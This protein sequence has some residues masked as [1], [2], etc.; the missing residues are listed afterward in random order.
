MPALVVTNLHVVLSRA[1]CSVTCAHCWAA[2][3]QGSRTLCAALRAPG[4]TGLGPPVRACARL[5]DNY[6]LH[7]GCSVQQV[8]LPIRLLDP[9]IEFPELAGNSVGL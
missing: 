8:Y 4:E 1:P 3:Y 9:Y 5:R 2:L 7:L 6:L